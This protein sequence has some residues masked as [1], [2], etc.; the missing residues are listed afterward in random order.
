M[1]SDNSYNNGK[2]QNAQYD[3]LV[4]DAEGKDANNANKRWDDMVKA[5][6]VLANDEGI[7]PLYQ[8]ATPQLV[9]SGIKG[10][11]YFPTAPIWD[12]SKV[13]VK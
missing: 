10:I 13:T 3:K 11:Q 9:K 1:T 4:A 12:W 2:W 6:K 7:V 5:E 8:Q